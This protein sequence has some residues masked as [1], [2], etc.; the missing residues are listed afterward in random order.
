M[1]AHGGRLDV[2]R[3]YQAAC[4][5]SPA[6]VSPVSL[7]SVSCDVCFGMSMAGLHVVPYVV[8]CWCCLKQWRSLLIAPLLLR[9]SHGWRRGVGMGAVYQLASAPCC[10]ATIATAGLAIGS[11]DNRTLLGFNVVGVVVAWI[12]ALA[13]LLENPLGAALTQAR[14]CLL[15]VVWY[16]I[17]GVTIVVCLDFHHVVSEPACCVL[18][19]HTRRCLPVSGTYTCLCQV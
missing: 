12:L 4:V 14:H 13:T 16:D 2:A 19:M 15:V 3:V 5:R 7:V 10:K 11:G 1:S 6:H 18:L 17:I 9:E 8:P